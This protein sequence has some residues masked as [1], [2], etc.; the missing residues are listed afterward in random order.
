MMKIETEMVT[1][2]VTEAIDTS[3]TLTCD[4][5]QSHESYGL[6]GYSGETLGLQIDKFGM[7]V[8]QQCGYYTPHDCHTIEFVICWDCVK[9]KI[10]TAKITSDF[11]D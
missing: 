9:N 8:M 4:M 2:T 10:P 1:R 6:N 11:G 3:V 5:C 7:R